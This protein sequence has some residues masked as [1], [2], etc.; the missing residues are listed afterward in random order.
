MYIGWVSLLHFIM[1]TQHSVTV[2]FGGEHHSTSWQCCI[3]N[4]K[5]VFL[6]IARFVYQSKCYS[7]TVCFF[8]MYLCKISALFMPVNFYLEW[9]R[10]SLAHQ[11][12]N[13]S[14]LKQVVAD[15]FAGNTGGDIGGDD[16]NDY[17]PQKGYPGT[18]APGENF[19][20][21]FPMSSL[22]R[23]LLHPWPAFQVRAHVL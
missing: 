11:R 12:Y 1:L 5:W 15:Y 7:S 20:Q 18:L 16:V 3:K 19:P 21:D 8:V 9:Q 4:K 2:I 13:R 22:P 6:I 23:R 14:S 17:I 10:W